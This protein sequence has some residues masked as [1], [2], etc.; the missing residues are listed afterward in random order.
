MKA[1]LLFL[2]ILMY[3]VTCFGQEEPCT[4]D[5]TL[6]DSTYNLWP[7][8]IVNLPIAQVNVD[9]ETHVQIKTPDEVGEVTG[10]PFEV[11]LGTELIPFMV[12][13]ADVKIDS[14][15]M[16]EVLGLPQGMSLYFS[17]PNATYM[18]NSVGCVT[19]FG[20]PTAEMMGTTHDIVFRIDGWVTVAEQVVALSDVGDLE[21]ITGY[22]FI[23]TENGLASVSYIANTEFKLGQNVPNPFDGYTTISFFADKKEAFKFTVVDLLGNKVIDRE[24]QS[25]TGENSIKLDGKDLSSGLYF[26]SLTNGTETITK[27]MLVASK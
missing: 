26:Y 23:V 24:I 25:Y 7:D 27:R 15:R 21:E 5:M 22:K 6:Q 3:S 1:L 13:V 12:D 18:G 2:S 14:I 19:L 8:T 10:Y 20:L 9:Y 17:E 11:N 4:P 16:V